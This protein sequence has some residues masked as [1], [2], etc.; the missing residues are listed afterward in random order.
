MSLLH[1]LSLPVL[2]ALLLL[3]SCARPVADFTWSPESG[4]AP[5]EIR[6]ENRSR[7]AK[8]FLWEFG[9]GASQT[10]SAPI[11]HFRESGN[12][13]VSLTAYRGKRSHR[14]EKTIQISAP[15]PCL[16]EILTPHGRMVVQLSDETPLHRDNF[17][18][19]VESGFYDSLL[20]HRIIRGFMIQGGDPNSRGAGPDVRLGSG[21]PGYQIDAEFRSSLV[22]HKGALCAARMGDGVN[23]LKKSSGSQ[24]YI[25]QG[26]KTSDNILDGVEARKE[27][28]YNAEQRE[29]Y[30]TLGGT[31]HLDLDYTVFGMVIEGLD[32]IDRITE[33]K[34]MPGDRPEKD[35]WMVLR[36]VK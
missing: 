25:V 17:I 1:R 36:I 26:N 13:P 35:V 2:F 20:F 8:A 23:P 15:E 10:E 32:V 5:A 3:A 4:S 34:T 16:V 19:L 27:F 22:H 24:F 29:T 30:K 11:H 31:P 21:G 9:D 28:R 6:F 12:F 14:L 33:A 7:A 18:K